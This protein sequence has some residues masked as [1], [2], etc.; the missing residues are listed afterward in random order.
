M[1][2][3]VLNQRVSIWNFYNYDVYLLM[4][5]VY[6]SYLNTDVENTKIVDERNTAAN[7]FL[8]V[9]ITI[10]LRLRYNIGFHRY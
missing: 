5:E 3:V 1:L 10:K 2:N 6:I 7:F 9:S 4:R 8:M